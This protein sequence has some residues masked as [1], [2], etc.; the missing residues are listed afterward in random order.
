MK[1]AAAFI[2]SLAL[3]LAAAPCV[4][5][6][7]AAQPQAAY[8]GYIVKVSEQAPMALCTL[9]AAS[10][11]LGAGFYL[12]DE[13]E[14]AG[15]IAD[16]Q[17]IEY[18]EP[19]YVLEAFDVP[20]G[21][22]PEA[23]SL[24]AVNAED[25]W[26]KGLYGDSVKVALID[27]GLRA[28]HEDLRQENILPVV[29][30]TGDGMTVQ[31][32]TGHG[33]IVGGVLAARA[34]NAQSPGTPVVD[35]AAPDV[36]VLPLRVFSPVKTGTV[37]MA[38]DAINYAVSADCDVINMSFGI[39]YYSS[40]LDEACSAAADAGLLLVAAAGNRGSTEYA[41]PAAL[42]S[43][44]SVAAVERTAD[45]TCARADFSQYN[46]QV[47]VTAP[48]A[49]IAS[50]SY[51]GDGAYVSGK[52]GTS[53]SAPLVTALAALAKEQN[54]A[55]TQDGF[56]ELL[57]ATAQDLGPAGRDVQYGYGMADFSAF[58]D[59]ITREYEIAFVNAGELEA[60]HYRLSLDEP[61]MLPT[62]QREAHLFSGW[63]GNEALTGDPVE[64]ILPGSV[65]DITLYAAWESEDAAEVSSVTVQGY[66]A[67]RAGDAFT[68]TLP[69]GSAVSAGD[70]DIRTLAAQA[71]VSAPAKD[72]D[73][74]RFSVT[75]SSGNV[76]KP[77]TLSIVISDNSAPQPVSDSVAGS[78]V[79]P[80]ADGLRA[81][82]AYTASA[83]AWFTDADAD[84]LRYELTDAGDAVGAVSLSAAGTLTYTPATEDAEK[85]L[86][87]RVR[88]YDGMFYSGEVEVCIAVAARP[89]SQPVLNASQLEY[90]LY[91]PSDT[92]LGV[93]LYEA[94]ITSVAF[95]AEGEALKPL[96]AGEDYS[97]LS[98]SVGTH[99]A[100]V[101]KSS[102]LM[103][104]STGRYVVEVSFSAGEA[105]S[106]TLTVKDSAPT[107]TVV[108]S[109]VNGSTYVRRENVRSGATV[110]LPA[111]PTREGFSFDGWYTG[112]NGAG[113]AF[114]AQTPITSDITVYAKW[115]LEGGGG[116]GG[117]GGGGM[118]PAVYKITASAGGGGSV[119]P[120][121]VE[122]E[123]GESATITV[124][125]DA[126]FAIS[127]ILVDG[128][129]VKLPDEIGT[130]YA[131][132]FEK[133]DASHTL[134]ARFTALT[135]VI[136]PMPAGALFDDVAPEDW[137]Y[138]AVGF[139]SGR[140]LFQ[141]T[142]E[143]MF[144]PD[145]AMTRAMLVTVL[146]RMEGEPV[147]QDTDGAFGDLTQ[148]WYIPAVRW[149]SGAGIA[150]GTGRVVTEN[151]AYAAFSPDAEITREQLAA[152][153]YRYAGYKGVEREAGGLDAFSDAA[154]ASA[155]ARE[156]LAWAVGAGILQGRGDA[157]LDPRGDASRCEVAAMLMRFMEAY[158]L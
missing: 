13:P 43:V 39:Y 17:F 96:R 141:G 57:I 127:Q 52:E 147:A 5:G 2:V 24:Q 99:D 80:S 15:A 9:D 87:L 117:G 89:A 158:G 67:A 100:L 84:E 74:W 104:K 142:G 150:D 94:Q 10:R 131:Y 151:G 68:V 152:L 107:Y 124:A 60:M 129:A 133:V 1:R 53:F 40:A 119:S 110:A 149:V 66:E 6:A 114:T 11:P 65:G 90:D 14:D 85:T 27:S 128:A 155:Y 35:G 105:R 95:A 102:F 75:S 54:R 36:T 48:G 37:A 115:I 38:V 55:L 22:T 97:V 86:F 143:R 123:E 16:E 61:L 72:G 112:K 140:S 18:I 118:M 93:T 25:A 130:S 121:S 146:W 45:G 101:L 31:D 76:T 8:E 62:P 98:S 109:A 135:E 106:A 145:A 69:K 144:S 49:G 33:T 137:F 134:E 4:Q 56:K 64:A 41:Y 83:G 3:L 108:F 82:Q 28:T 113:R 7:A 77:Y 122:V 78:A 153:L 30:F 148:D 59:E 120:A 91:A 111:Q 73:I 138:D 21:Y 50:L 63:Y 19:N 79:P 44:V 23:W 58:A 92:E 47:F 136:E 126:G 32:A 20:D 156:P 139:V 12:V 70:V 81:A 157:M 71:A 132:T 116:F 125:P 46:N 34:G 51:T 88:A 29:N 26:A 154:Q 42:D 103:G